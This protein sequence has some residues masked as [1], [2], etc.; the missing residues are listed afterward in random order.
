M[1]Q[2]K[3]SLG[4]E[5]V[6]KICSQRASFYR[7]LAR[8]FKIEVDVAFLYITRA[9]QPKV[10]YLASFQSK[11]EF[12]EGSRLLDELSHEIKAIKTNQERDSLLTDLA[13]EFARMFLAVG[14]KPVFL[15]ESA[16]RTVEHVNYGS[17]FWKVKDAYQS[18]GFEKAKDFT[19]PED[20]ISVEF[21]FM[22]QLCGWTETSLE[23]N[24]FEYAARYLKLQKEFL[25]EHLAQ[26]A[27]GVCDGIRGATQSTFYLALAYLTKGFLT[28][29][30]SLIALLESQLAAIRESLPQTQPQSAQS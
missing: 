14:K 24:D 26:W 21:D 13:V 29:E 9:L 15:T 19:E 2:G 3:E 17:Y 8:G 4:L 25:D 7:F 16:N 28:M 1:N 23:K 22:A 18:L 30:G 27:F 6:R 5:D 10:A 11:G 12:A 20:H